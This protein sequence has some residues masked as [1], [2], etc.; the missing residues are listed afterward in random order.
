[1]AAKF[2]VVNAKDLSG[3]AKASGRP[4][5]MRIVGGLFTSED[6]VVELGEITFM[7]GDNRPLPHVVPGQTYTPVIGATS[8][9]GKLIFQITELKPLAVRAAA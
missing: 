6:G 7:Q 5:N 4:Y 8:R 2:Q 1:M 3:T 9:D